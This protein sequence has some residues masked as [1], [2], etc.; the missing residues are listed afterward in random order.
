MTKKNL[1][2]VAAT[3]LVV[4]LLGCPQ[5]KKIGELT[6]D[7]QHYVNKDIAIKGTVV[8]SFGAVVAGLYQIDDGTGKMWVISNGNVPTKGTKI[9]VRGR[10]EPGFSLG[11]TSYGT[12]LRE[13]ERRY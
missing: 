12:T 1:L 7:P 13:R 5:E 8:N 11:G 10:L 3:L 6:R 2:A 9:G 4:F